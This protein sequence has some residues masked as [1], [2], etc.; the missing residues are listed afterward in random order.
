L[1]SGTGLP[2][3]FA[4]ED[5]VYYLVKFRVVKLLEVLE[6]E[7]KMKLEVDVRI[8]NIILDKLSLQYLSSKTSNNL[9]HTRPGYPQ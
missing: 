1:T 3:L 5:L 9:W 7:K 8:L 6:M 2:L 4:V